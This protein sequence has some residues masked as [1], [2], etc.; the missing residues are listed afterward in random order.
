MNLKHPLCLILLGLNMVVFSQEKT[1]DTLF[2]PNKRLNESEQ[3]QKIITI[4]HNDTQ[5]NANN[6]SEVLRFQT[7]VYIK[8]NGRG[9]VSSPSFRG[10]TAQ[11]TAFVWNGININSIF[12]GQ[13]DINNIGLLNFD[14]ISVKAGG[15]SISY[16]TGA[17]GGS[18]HL[19]DEI[20][21]NKGFQGNIFSEYGSFNTMNANLKLTYSNE[22]FSLK[23]GTALAKSENDYEVPSEKYK[24]LNGQYYQY[25]YALSGA[26]RFDERYKIAVFSIWNTGLQHY[27][28]FSTTQT[29]TKYATNGLKTMLNLEAKWGKIQNDI[30][31]AFLRDGYDYFANTHQPKSN[32]AVGDTWLIRNDFSLQNDEKLKLNFISEYQYN[33][34]KGYSS[35][36]I[37]PKRNAGYLAL[38][39]QKKLTPKF[40]LEGSVRKDWV[41]NIQSP[42]LY[43]LATKIDFSN[44][45]QLKISG[46]KNFRYPTFND[47]YWQLGGNLDLKSEIAYQLEMSHQIRIGKWKIDIVPFFN[48]IENMIQWLPTPAG[49][50]SPFNTRKIRTYGVE[51][52]TNFQQKLGNFTLK[53]N[54]NYAYTH[55]ENSETKKILSYVPQ[56]KAS[57]TIALNHK[58]LDI[59]GQALFTSD[60][61]TTTD[62]NQSLALPYYTIANAGLDFHLNKN[63]KIGGKI[64]NIFNQVY[65]TSD[66][67]PLPL[68]NY[69]INLNINF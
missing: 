19:D 64:N 60:V 56:H 40:L 57:G 13:G 10:T 17:I 16:G 38:I 5:R 9:M 41:E 23:F 63:I 12:L 29:R 45:Y 32:G 26:Y 1:I 68:R 67:Y 47:L 15:G 66:Y 44:H 25:N 35:G 20:L 21:F 30:K 28:I 4:N 53:I 8:E 58:W 22:K 2:I 43:S 39:A 42:I 55:A 34:A 6:L 65:K 61:F 52:Y 69:Q 54:G 18:V 11:Q 37:N 49:H 31:M 48:N 14:K 62:E 33:S 46:S 59:F 24:N 50:W 27:P 51:F 7:P 3:F 36:I